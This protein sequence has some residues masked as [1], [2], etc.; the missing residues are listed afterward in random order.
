MN[1]AQDFVLLAYA[2]DGTPE[3]DSTRLDNGAGGA[4][5]L[6]LALDERVGVQDTKVVVRDSSPTGDAQVDA[7]LA[8][9]AGDGRP[10]KPDHWVQH[11]ARYARQ[12]A[13]DELVG[14]G[15]LQREKGTVLLVFP[16]TTY[17]A[18]GGVEPPA[19]TETRARLRAAVAGTGP[20]EPRTAALCALVAA[21]DLDRKVFPD[22]DRK[23]VKGRLKEIGEGSW[24]ADAV[25]QTIEQIQAA[26]MIAVVAATSASTAATVNGS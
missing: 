23:Q 20:V 15:V 2:D 24:A 26:V 16:R 10:R 8:E 1:L 18:T 21:T 13:L 6:E 19:E 9:V 22:L 11:F 12:Q 4:L 7:A 17:P 14:R 5:L 3:T 25:K